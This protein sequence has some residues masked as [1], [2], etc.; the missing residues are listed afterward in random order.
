LY[1]RV[2]TFQCIVGKLTSSMDGVQL[3]LE[4]RLQ[5]GRS[6]TSAMGAGM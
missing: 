3:V 1:D 6:G 2:Q 5:R 4:I